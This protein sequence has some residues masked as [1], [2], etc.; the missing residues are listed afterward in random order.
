MQS[1]SSGYTFVSLYKSYPSYHGA[2]DITYN[3]F[4]NWPNKNKLLLQITNSN[5]SKNKIINI[6]KK[7][8]LIGILMNFLLI[9]NKMNRFLENYKKKYLIIEGASW[10]GYI[11]IFI[12]LNKIINRDLIIIYHAHNLEYEVR[13]LKNNSIIS[14]ITFYFEKFIYKNTLPTA[15]SKNDLK[16]IKKYYKVKPILFENGV[17][18]IKEEKF[19][20]KKIKPK[21]FILFCG[22]YTYW[23]NEFAI[24][25]ILKKKNIIN[26]KFTDI[27]FVFTGEGFPKYNDRDILNIGIIK[28]S[29]LIWLIKNC[30]FFYAPMPKAPGTKMKIL[31]ALY[32]NA[33]TICSKQAIRGIRKT[34][35]LNSLQITNDK[36]FLTILNKI[37]SKKK[38]KTSS[39]F[40]ENYNY[41][42][43]TQIFYEKVI[44]F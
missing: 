10:A 31:E 6:K 20:N 13:K 30:L 16:F 18:E 12:I 36:N 39:K 23:P 37:K 1:N 26:K 5:I 35:N 34:K 44:R 43:K 33:L 41:K 7:E 25:N 24:K 29:K 32:Y 9:I 42:K 14:F 19:Y 17:T 38:F 8:N 4:Q 21:K 27:K 11:F 15:V 3:F 28:K 2:S 40:K 22:S